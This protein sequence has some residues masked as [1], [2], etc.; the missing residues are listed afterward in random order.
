MTQVVHSVNATT[1]AAAGRIAQLLAV[2]APAPAQRRWRAQSLADGAV[3]IALLHIERA[4]ASPANGTQRTR[5]SSRQRGPRSFAT[6]DAGLYPG[7]P[8]VAFALHAATT[9]GSDK[10]RRSL[11][12]LDRSVTALTHRRVDQAH[13]R[14]VHG[15]LPKFAEFDVIS[16]LAG[17]GAH[18]PHARR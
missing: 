11:S 16:G 9:G 17:V 5:G 2:P 1:R 8:A 13:A 10:Y 3:G 18:L 15:Q 6:T 4:H 7:A 14:I 12:A